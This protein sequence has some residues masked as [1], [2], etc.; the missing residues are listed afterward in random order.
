LQA[1]RLGRAFKILDVDG[2]LAM[3]AD[4]LDQWDAYLDLE[5]DAI[6]TL[7]EEMKRK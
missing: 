7:R 4:L 1:F 2:I 3:P 5:R 6:E